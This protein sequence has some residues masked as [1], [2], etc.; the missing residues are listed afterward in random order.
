MRLLAGRKYASGNRWCAWRWT[1]VDPE[2]EGKIYLTRLHLFQTP[3][4]SCMVHW[5]RL[6]DP[7]PDLHDHPVTFVS[8]LVAGWYEEEVPASDGGF[9]LRRVRWWNVKRATDRHRIVKLGRT[10]VTLV[11]A[12]PVVRDWGF[13]TAEGWMPWR[14]YVARRQAARQPKGAIPIATNSPRAPSLC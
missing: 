1:D 11:L 12:G 8:L 10:V 5:I 14:E 4:L 2:N 6:A 13:H 3:W 7:Q 9:L